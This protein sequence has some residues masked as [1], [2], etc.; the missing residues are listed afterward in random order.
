[1]KK[2][3]KLEKVPFFTFLIRKRAIGVEM[4]K[5]GEEKPGEIFLNDSRNFV[6][7]QV[8]SAKFIVL[9]NIKNYNRH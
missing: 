4:K 1:V 5:K 8:V 2:I 7:F 3:K 9:K 6:V